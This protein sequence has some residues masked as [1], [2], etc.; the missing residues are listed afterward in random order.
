LFFNKITLTFAL[1]G[2]SNKGSC[3]TPPPSRVTLALQ[4][5]VSYVLDGE[6]RTLVAHHGKVFEGA[7]VLHGIQLSSNIVKVMIEEIVIPHALVLVPIGE[8]YIVAQTFQYFIVWPNIRLMFFFMRR[9]SVNFEWVR[10]L[11]VNRIG[12]C[13][14][15]SW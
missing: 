13:E 5:N 9:I 10:I 6:G 11:Y 15:D 7:K 12:V 14:V 2:R 3:S 1:I 8:V 4:A